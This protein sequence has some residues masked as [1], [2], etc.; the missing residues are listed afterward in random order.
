MIVA[1]F[2]NLI[3]PF[4]VIS[5]VAR[6]LIIIIKIGRDSSRRYACSE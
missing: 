1:F 4:F 3:V 2:A 6:N 5:R